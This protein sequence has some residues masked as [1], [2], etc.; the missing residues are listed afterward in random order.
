MSDITMR[1]AIEQ[2]KWILEESDETKDLE[3]HGVSV[4]GSM[5]VALQA[6]ENQKTG[7]WIDD[8]FGTRCSCCNIHTHLDKFGR[9]MILLHCSFCGAKMKGENNTSEQVEKKCENCK[10]WNGGYVTFVC[11]EC[12]DKS[13]WKQN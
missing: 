5:K 8:E 2:I 7:H 1:E 13:E 12:K 3:Y 10:Y 11:C 6:L 9:P 4:K